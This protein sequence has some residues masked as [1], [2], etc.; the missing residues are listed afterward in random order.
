MKLYKRPDSEFWWFKLTY[1]GRLYQR[2]TKVANKRDAE[3]IASSFR[4][5]LIKDEVGIAKRVAPTLKE[6]QTR[7]I[8]HVETHHANKP[9]TVAFYTDR[10]RRLVEWESFANARLH[11]IDADLIDRYKTMRRKK[12]GIVSVNRE[13]ATLRKLLRL[14]NEWKVIKTVPKVKLLSGEPGRDFVLDYET[15]KTYLAICK[16][17]APLLH[18]TAVLLLDTGLR[19]SEALALTWEH[20][21][22]KPVGDAKYGYVQIADGKSK[23]AKRTVPLMSRSNDM[24]T[25]R[26]K[27]SKS[28]WVYP[29]DSPENPVLGTSLDHIHA[30]ICRPG[31]GKKRQF[32]FSAEFVLHS[33]RH[34]ALT[35]WGE[36]GADAFTIMKLAGHSSVIVSQRYVHPTPKGVEMVF[37]RLEVLNRKALTATGGKS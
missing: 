2:S 11:R 25:Q 3:N 35:R 4:T 26:K 31:K 24:L 9:R 14:A 36:A 18:D 7:F 16:E 17:K 28:I 13:L 37:D 21:H 12:V 23:N 32:V 29:G 8:E 20:V 15:E 30:S 33:C 19:L 10:M 6:F 27:M 34:T 5:S 1:E 22:L